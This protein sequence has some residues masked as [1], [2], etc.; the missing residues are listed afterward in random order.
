[1]A[2]FD[3]SVAK[4]ATEGKAEFQSA[5]QKMKADAEVAR[6]NLERLRGVGDKSWSALKTALTE[7]RTAFDRADHAV[8]EAFKRAA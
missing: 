5:L 6:A 4:L 2:A 1:M 7:T 8:Y 3:R